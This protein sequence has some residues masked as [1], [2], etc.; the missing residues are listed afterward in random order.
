MKTV[1]ERMSFLNWV[2]Q[3]AHRDDPVGDLA[4][5]SKRVVAWCGGFEGESAKHVADNMAKFGACDAA[6]AALRDAKREYRGYIK[7]EATLARL[8]NGVEKL[9]QRQTER[10]EKLKTLVEMDNRGV[11]ID[12]SKH[13]DVAHE[14]VDLTVAGMILLLAVYSDKDHIICPASIAR[15]FRTLSS[16]D[17]AQAVENLTRSIQWGVDIGLLEPLPDGKY[18]F[19]QA[20]VPTA[21]DHETNA[22]WF[23]EQLDNMQGAHSTQIAQSYKEK[24]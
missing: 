22:Q 16:V 15:S 7:G 21:M 17:G 1:P 12:L 4:R 9:E 13:S 24:N 2:L 5:E 18:L 8:I 6:W 19:H 14:L 3:Q 20:V 23:V 10:M 11:P